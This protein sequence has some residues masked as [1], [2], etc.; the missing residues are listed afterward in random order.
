YTLSVLERRERNRHVRPL[1]AEVSLISSHAPWTPIP[2][3]LED[4]SV[5]GDGAVFSR[6]AQDGDPPEVVWRDPER[7]RHQYT[8][9]IDYVLGV[10]ASYAS[11]FVDERTLMI[12]VGDHQPA[13]LITGEDAGRDV[14]IHVIAGDP[15]LLAPFRDWGLAAGMRPTGDSI[16]RMDR[17]RDRFLATFSE[18]PQG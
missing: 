15:E 2:P 17:F 9:A 1:F 6:W 10:L 7:V 13:P 4:W 14:P 12:V 16:G 8:L 5:I 11:R 3:V 18:Q